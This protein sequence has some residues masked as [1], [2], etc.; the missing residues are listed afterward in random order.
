MVNGLATKATQ[1]TKQGV[2]QPYVHIKLEEWLPFWANE[3][4]NDGILLPAHT[5]LGMC[6]EYCFADKDNLEEGDAVQ[7]L[8]KA[9]IL[10]LS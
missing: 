5:C 3:K 6:S 1:L 7:E 8:A 10:F 4:Q 2:R 9:G